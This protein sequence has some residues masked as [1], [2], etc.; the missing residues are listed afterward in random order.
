MP[1]ELTEDALRDALAVAGEWDEDGA[2]AAQSALEWLGWEGEGP[3][4]LRRYDVQLFVW[5]TLPRKFLTTL[6]HKRDAADQLAR[7]LE[8][9][10]GRAASYAQ[11]CRS[12]ETEELL[13]AWESE[14]PA[15]RLRFRELLE[16]SGLEPP[17]TD[18]LAW[19][20]VMGY[21]EA[22]AREQV[23]TALEQAVEAGLLAPGAPGFRRRRAEVANGALLEPIDGGN[24]RS[25]LDA[26]HAERLEHWLERGRTRGSSE[27][28]AIIEPIAQQLAA[29]PPS[30]NADA[31]RIA[32]APALWLLELGDAGIALTQT[33]ALNRALVR[34]AAERWSGWWNAEIH[35]PPHRE[36]DVALLCELHELLRRRRLLRRSGCRLLTTAGGRQLAADPTELLLALATDLLADDDFRGAC[37]ELAVA[38]L[39]AG[40]EADWSEPLAREIQPAIVAEGWQSSGEP[41]DVRDVSWAI[42]DFIRPA[43]AAGLIERQPEF[44]F[45]REPLVLSEPGRRALIAALRTRARAPRKTPF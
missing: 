40:F 3:L 1:V 7:T 31:A 38:L 2:R 28:H 45:H 4:L 27:R 43:T 17:D 42:A 5:Y 44:P 30:I 23:A 39:L 41:P 10:G 8:Q 20:Q 13:H 34:E 26:V 37:A 25:R 15:A 19:G 21:E 6:D 18:L 9:L 24:G 32:L 16:A 11:V 29:P 14:D 35:G 33:G 36:T 22:C 12:P